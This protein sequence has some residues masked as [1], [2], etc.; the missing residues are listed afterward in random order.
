MSWNPVDKVPTPENVVVETISP[1][2][3]Q[4]KLMR[5]GKLWFHPDGQMYVY[6]TPTFW[7][8]LS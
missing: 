7:R 1:S 6:Y 4:Q 3:L 5:I 8:H 2:G